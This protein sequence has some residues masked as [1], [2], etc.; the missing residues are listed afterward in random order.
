[1]V[2][3]VGAAVVLALALGAAMQLLFFHLDV[4]HL[5]GTAVGTSLAIAI[6]SYWH[7]FNQQVQ[8]R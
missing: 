8:K 6:V 2:I 5:L 1:V 3:A 4:S 7:R